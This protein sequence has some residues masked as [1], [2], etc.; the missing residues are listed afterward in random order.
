MNTERRAASGHRVRGEI[1]VPVG[2]RG[3]SPGAH[4]TGQGTVTAGTPQW[5]EERA[6]LQDAVHGGFDGAQLRPPRG[7][8]VHRALKLALFF[9]N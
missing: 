3:E 9:L 2:V 8:E 5:K 1:A 6:E 4:R 7:R